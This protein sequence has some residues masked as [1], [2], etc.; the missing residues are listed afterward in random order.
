MEGIKF[1]FLKSP[2]RIYSLYQFSSKSTDFKIFDY[3]MPRPAPPLDHALENIIFV[4]SIP[5]LVSVQIFSLIGQFKIFWWRHDHALPRPFLFPAI[6]IGLSQ[7]PLPIVRLSQDPSLV[8]WNL[9]EHVFWLP[10]VA[11]IAPDITTAHPPVGECWFIIV[12]NE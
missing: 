5:Y 2:G 10:R 9:S 8:V 4:L 11:I 7:V 3:V 6:V 1:I 12:D